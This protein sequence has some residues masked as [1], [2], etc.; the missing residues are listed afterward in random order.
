MADEESCELRQA[1]AYGLSLCAFSGDPNA[2][3]P[4]L[5]EATQRLVAGLNRPDA[6][7]SSENSCATDNMVSALGRVAVRHDRPALLPLWL[8]GLPIRDD[9]S[10]RGDHDTLIALLEQGV[11]HGQVQCLLGSG[12]NAHLPKL[13]T[14]LAWLVADE[15]TEDE[16][17]V[18]VLR[19]VAHLLSNLPEQLMQGA[20]ATLPPEE[21]Q[22]VLHLC[23]LSQQ[24][25]S[26]N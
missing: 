8:S 7:A 16:L 24:F 11:G 5:D 6:R 18:R 21:Q 20:C 13:L 2:F 22:Q 10:C 19:V 9:E 4:Y 17:K 14:V 3:R 1:A 15:P 12:S 25:A 26:S 23:Q